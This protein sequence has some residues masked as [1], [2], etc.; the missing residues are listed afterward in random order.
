MVTYS[1]A[2]TGGLGDWLL[3]AGASVVEAAV[4]GTSASVAVGA[5]AGDCRASSLVTAGTGEAAE[6]A[7][8]EAAAG[9]EAAVAGAASEAGAGV[10]V[11]DN[12][13][14]AGWAAGL[15]M[16]SAAATDVEGCSAATSIMVRAVR[17]DKEP[18]KATLRRRSG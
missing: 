16:D 18:E 1:D 3:V 14:V 7:A 5:A 6:A 12:D 8:A 10:E 17:A 4:A 15:S 2:A 11:V 9:S 13:T